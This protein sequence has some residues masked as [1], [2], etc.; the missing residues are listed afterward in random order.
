MTNKERDEE[1]RLD[2]LTKLGIARSYLMRVVMI[3]DQRIDLGPDCS[4][5]MLILRTRQRQ[6]LQIV[7]LLHEIEEE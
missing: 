1:L 6:L 4:E 2:V 5:D 7:Q 3:T